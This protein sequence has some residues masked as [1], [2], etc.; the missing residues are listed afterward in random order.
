M[1][2]Q[3]YDVL[4]AGFVTVIFCVD[5]DWFGSVLAKLP[6][7]CEVLCCGSELM[8]GTLVDRQEDLGSNSPTS[9]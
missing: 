7:V 1:K 6:Q 5:V 8:M 2:G 3:S 4:F 9:K